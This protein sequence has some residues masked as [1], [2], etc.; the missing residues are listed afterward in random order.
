MPPK[1]R[2][3]D[4][5]G[6]ERERLARENADAQAAR[7][8]ELGL[9]TAVAEEKKSTEILDATKP[10]I[11]VPTVVDEIESVGVELETQEE[12][13]Q[14]VDDIQQMTFGAG[15]HY[16]FERGRKYKVTKALADHL[17]E[18]GYVL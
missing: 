13:I 8:K 12:V 2:P 16:D 5:T 15:N 4:F 17:R 10:N 6:Q 18:K 11:P 7:A 1:A 3:A 9:A 14:V